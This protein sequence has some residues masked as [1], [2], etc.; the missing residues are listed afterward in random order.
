MIETLGS[1]VAGHEA[2]AEH[3]M[4]ALVQMMLGVVN[5]EHGLKLK[6]TF[7]SAIIIA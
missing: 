1:L 5:G 4:A 2:T 3:F 7:L 6:L